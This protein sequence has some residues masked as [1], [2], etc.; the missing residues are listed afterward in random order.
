MSV[1]H[2]K[3]KPADTIGIN[4]FAAVSAPKIDTLFRSAF[5]LLRALPR[6]LDLSYCSF[7]AL[8]TPKAKSSRFESLFTSDGLLVMLAPQFA[9]S[10]TPYRSIIKGS[11]TLGLVILLG[12]NLTN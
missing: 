7:G 8:R 12:R 5:Y 11:L 4:R 2:S 10:E 3:D 9:F 1:L 6:G